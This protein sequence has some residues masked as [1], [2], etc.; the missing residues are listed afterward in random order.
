MTAG[1]RLVETQVELP[2]GP[3]A[4]RSFVLTGRLPTLTRG[5]AQTLIEAAGGR[6]TGSVGKTTDYVVA[7]EDPGSKY[8]RARRLGIAIVDE[9]GLR[10]LLGTPPSA[11]GT[12]ERRS[13]S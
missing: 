2:P 12:G 9:G 1:V 10:E 4:G 5:Q 7:G 11:D 13:P 8:D 3:L 6:V